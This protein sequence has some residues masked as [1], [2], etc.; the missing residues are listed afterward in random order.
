MRV[1]LP[2]V[3]PGWCPVPSMLL[4]EMHPSSSAA[5]GPD[6]KS[7][8]GAEHDGGAPQPAFGP[9]HDE[10]SQL[11]TETGQPLVHCD[12]A[13]FC[14]EA[15]W[16]VLSPQQ[17]TWVQPPPALMQFWQATQSATAGMT[18]ETAA[19]ASKFM[20]HIAARSDR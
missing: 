5:S 7:D 19:I 17:Y 10:Q 6:T 8:P 2:V 12:E 9:Q 16:Q 4:R 15:D 13:Q 20:A 3:H 1:V 11:P 18:S 14:E